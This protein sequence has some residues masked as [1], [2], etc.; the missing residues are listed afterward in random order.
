MRDAL[1][2]IEEVSTDMPRRASH[3]SFLSA[4]QMSKHMALRL[5]LS[6]LTR[7]MSTLF[8]LFHIVKHK[9]K[10]FVRVLLKLLIPNRIFGSLRFNTRNRTTKSSQLDTNHVLHYIRK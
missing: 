4:P 2:T 10:W 9:L 3:L 6:Q 5:R 8:I 7:S 1:A